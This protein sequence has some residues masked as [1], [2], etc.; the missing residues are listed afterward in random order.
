MWDSL[1]TDFYWPHALMVSFDGFYAKFLMSRARY[2]N[3]IDSNGFPLNTT[4]CIRVD[5]STA[6]PL[7]KGLQGF[8]GRDCLA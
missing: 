7:R 1:E 2:D 4:C 8:E 5:G 3:C 6:P